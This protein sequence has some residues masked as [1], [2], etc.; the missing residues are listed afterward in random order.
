MHATLRP[1][2]AGD[3]GRGIR[4]TFYPSDRPEAGGLGAALPRL[5]GILVA[6]AVVRTVVATL[7]RHHAGGASRGGR[8]R[9]MIAALHRELHAADAGGPVDG[10]SA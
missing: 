8:R 9:D 3:A 6:M 7:A 10:A 2:N 1:R 5:V 4:G